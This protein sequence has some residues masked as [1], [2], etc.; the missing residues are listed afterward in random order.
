MEQ[1]LTR[2]WYRE[3]PGFSPLVPLAWLYGAVVQA[4]RGAYARGWLR[5]FPAGRPVV[6]VGNLTV[7][8]TGKTPLVIWLARAL[9]QRGLRVGLVSRGHGAEPAQ[10]PRAVSEGSRWQEVGDEPLI[11]FQRTGCPTVVARDRVAGARLLAAQG[12]DVILADDG[13]Q[14]LRLER[15]CEILVVDGIRGF[16]NGLLLPA[17][18]LREPVA[19]ARQADL[20]VINGPPQ[21][22]SLAALK[23][24]AL[25]MRLQPAAALP[26]SGPPVA[27]PL[28]S[29]RGE[30]LHA[31]AGIGHPARFFAMLRAHGLSIIEHAFPDH[32]P[33]APAD[34]SF[35]DALAVIMTEKDAVKCRSFA[36]T[37]LWYLP[38]AA[39]FSEPEA[40]E[41]LVRV[42]R[43][44][45]LPGIAVAPA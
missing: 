3:S 27:R 29:F 20:I 35:T 26:V 44:L 9:M 30:P 12:A 17:G 1:R 45:G 22:V 13:L 42:S 36:G 43:K 34:L 28:E 18:P 33:F 16:G 40:H 10:E 15:D 38:V 32:H 25:S 4:R 23:P 41:L 6:V 14:H 31:V 5:S 11:L 21:H 24:G 7:G 37:R 2:H 39:A 19:R 8:G